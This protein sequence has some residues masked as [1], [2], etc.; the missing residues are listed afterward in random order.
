[1]EGEDRMQLHAENLYDL[2]VRECLTRSQR[3]NAVYNE[4]GLRAGVRDKAF[5]TVVLAADIA[6]VHGSISIIGHP[7]LTIKSRAGAQVRVIREL[8]FHL[9]SIRISLGFSMAA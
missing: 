3:L 5:N 8:N 9:S 2:P 4:T 7:G 6:L 1:M